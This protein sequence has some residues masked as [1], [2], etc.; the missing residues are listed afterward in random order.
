M[1]TYRELRWMLINMPEEH[2]D[3]NVSILLM[4]SN[5][6]RPVIDVVTEWPKEELDSEGLPTGDYDAMQTHK[7]EGILDDG[8][9]YLT[10]DD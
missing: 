2:L 8:H 3:K 7:V 4:N 1:K 9:S 10:V 6:V 5:E